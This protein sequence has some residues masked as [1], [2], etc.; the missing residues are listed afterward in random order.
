[1]Y[2]E[3]LEDL[4]L[5]RMRDIDPA[6]LSQHKTRSD[7]GLFWRP[8][9]ETDPP[10]HTD[11]QSAH[12]QWTV[13]VDKVTQTWEIRDLPVP[14]EVSMY[15]ARVALHRAGLLPSI[16]ALMADPSTDPEAVIAWEYGTAMVHNSPFILALAPA[17]GL[18]EAQID[19]L[20]WTASEVT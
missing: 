8:I 16:E 17:L 9:V 13:E 6:K 10:Y 20:F 18:T 3:I 7:G 15:Q 12:P 2:Y 5:G 11:R 4:S 14:T 19:E 1:M